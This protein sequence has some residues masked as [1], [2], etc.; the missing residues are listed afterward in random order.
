MSRLIHNEYVNNMFCVCIKL[1]YKRK[2]KYKSLW[3]RGI[4]KT[5]MTKIMKDMAIG[6]Q[7][8]KKDGSITRRVTYR[9]TT[10]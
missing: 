7:T 3:D 4:M 5:N 2:N 8:D 6:R 1:G 10:N 9:Q